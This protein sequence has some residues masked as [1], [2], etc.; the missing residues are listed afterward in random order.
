MEEEIELLRKVRKEIGELFMSDFKDENKAGKVYK[1]WQEVDNFLG[2]KD[3][4]KV[5]GKYKKD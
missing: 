5:F 2:K 3:I 4:E 1:L